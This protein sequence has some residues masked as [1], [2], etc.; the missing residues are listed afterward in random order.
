[1]C[2]RHFSQAFFFGC[3][4]RPLHPCRVQ[5]TD[6]TTTSM[7]QTW[8]HT[9]SQR[10]DFPDHNT[11]RSLITRSDYVI[12]SIKASTLLL[13]THATFSTSSAALHHVLHHADSKT[14]SY[15]PS[16]GAISRSSPRQELVVHTS[17]RQEKYG[18]QKY[19]RLLLDRRC[20]DDFAST[21]EVWTTSPRQEK[22]GRLLLDR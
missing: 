14:I 6:L 18:R 2:R 16:T 22:Y 20:M 12:Y 10:L 11:W 19:G 15:I 1:M 4:S 9:T 17:P 13:S 5:L 21:G 8:Q 3:S 7:A